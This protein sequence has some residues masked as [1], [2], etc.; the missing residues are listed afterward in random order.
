VVGC[1]ISARSDTGGSG[2]RA[3]LVAQMR[4]NTAKTEFATRRGPKG[5]GFHP[6]DWESLATLQSWAGASLDI[7]RKPGDRGRRTGREPDPSDLPK[8]PK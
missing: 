5:T 3:K 1:R 7:K 8:L 4:P 2:R 6:A